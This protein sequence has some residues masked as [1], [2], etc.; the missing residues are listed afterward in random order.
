MQVLGLGVYGVW[1][2]HGWLDRVWMGCGLGGCS[3][4]EA[5]MV[6][7]CHGVFC[8]VPP[9]RVRLLAVP[10]RQEQH[11]VATSAMLCRV[12]LV[13]PPPPCLFA[14][15][16]VPHNPGSPYG[17]PTRTTLA[18]QSITS[19]LLCSTR[20]AQCRSTMAS[21]INLYT[22]KSSGHCARKAEAWS[23]ATI[24]SGG[25][26]P[27]RQQSSHI[28]CWRAHCVPVCQPVDVEK[29]RTQG[30]GP[31]TTKELPVAQL[32]QQ[33]TSARSAAE[34]APTAGCMEEP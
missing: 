32:P 12:P 5:C 23:G 13:P 30:P 9:P 7:G 33:Q 15:R 17:P 6:S 4:A 29:A 8:W 21:H 2:G 20:A 22:Y 14:L 31:A 27:Q 18:S 10:A 24:H 1:M 16:S 25:P 11:N 28:S 19:T 3:V 26:G 34:M